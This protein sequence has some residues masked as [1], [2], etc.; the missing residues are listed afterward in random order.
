MG[1]STEHSS[2]LVADHHGMTKFKKKQD[3]NYIDVRNALRYLV[4][5]FIEGYDYSGKA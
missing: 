2:S 3:S 4:R 1:Y 5:D